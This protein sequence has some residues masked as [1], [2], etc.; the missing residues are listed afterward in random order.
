M[1]KFRKCWYCTATVSRV[2]EIDTDKVWTA[3]APEAN[4]PFVT[5][6]RSL[7][8]SFFHCVLKLRATLRSG[9][10]QILSEFFLDSLYVP[11]RKGL[12]STWVK[13]PTSRDLNN[14][15]CRWPTLCLFLPPSLSPPLFLLTRHEPN[16]S[17]DDEDRFVCQLEPQ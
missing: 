15:W 11:G 17:D 2:S 8:A 7:D 4:V 13:P 9:G 1:S 16:N 6:A 5:L 14:N 3:V 12:S 10:A